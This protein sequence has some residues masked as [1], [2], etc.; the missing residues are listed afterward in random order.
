MAQIL[1]G[2]Y[3]DFEDY[4][5]DLTDRVAT[6]LLKQNQMSV[7][8][9]PF[10]FIVLIAGRRFGKTYLAIAKLIET[11]IRTAGST[12]WYIAPTYR[13][14]K[15]IAW[16]ILKRYVPKHMRDEINEQELR[17]VLTNGSEISLKGA[18]NPDSLRG[19]GLHLAVL[20][21]FQDM[22]SDVWGTVIRPM[23]ATTG[24]RAIFIG[25]PKGYNHF[26]DLFMQAKMGLAGWGAFHFTTLQG[27][28]VP[29]EE[30]L[31]VR[32]DPTITLREFKQEW[33]A[34][35]ENLTGR[36]Y[37][38]FSRIA[39][40]KTVDYDHTAP[41]VVGM[42]FNIDPM[43]ASL[44]HFLNNEL[45]FF[46][47]VSIR[48]SNTQEMSEEI[49]RRYPLSKG[50]LTCYP[51]PAGKSGS[52]KAVVGTTDYTILKQNGFKV[53]SPGH[54]YKITDRVNTVNAMLKNASGVRRMFFDPINCARTIKALDGQCYK[55]GTKIPDKT[56][57]LD[58]HCDN[59][60]YLTCGVS[61]L[62]RRGQSMQGGF[63]P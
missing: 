10:R 55:E 28:Y 33:E 16:R 32:M 53:Y 56:A 54:A 19:V 7:F 29:L 51:D 37:D 47:E 30:V 43:T 6:L 45:R 38:N 35:F 25:T 61:P 62:K 11:A 50:R 17:I 8:T 2:I 9:S 49:H 44:A 22:A 18:D 15:M 34:S 46:D 14:A 23:L 42:D 40:I 4:D 60:G 1:N 41:V 3:E 26:Y 63:R 48:N 58:H 20:D 36:V 27:G 13:Q 39:N 5:D 59:V 12:S 57:G 24:G 52:T 21:E 31:E